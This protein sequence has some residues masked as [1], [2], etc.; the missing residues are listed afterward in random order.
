MIVC[1]NCRTKLHVPVEPQTGRRV[2]CPKCRAAFEAAAATAHSDSGA[3]DSGGLPVVQFEGFTLV[4]AEDDRSGGGAWFALCCLT[5]AILAAVASLWHFDVT[6]RE[7]VNGFLNRNA[8]PAEAVA[9]S[10]TEGTRGKGDAAGSRSVGP[11]S[12]VGDRYAL[13]V[14]V[15]DYSKASGLKPLKFTGDDARELS[16]VLE[17]N[18][19]RDENVVLMTAAEAGPQGRFSPR[20]RN[21]LHELKTLVRDRAAGDSLLVAF[22]GHGV[23]LEGKSY[24]CPVDARLSDKDTLI[25]MDDVYETLRT[26]KA[27]LKLMLLDAC[28]DDPFSSNSRRAEVRLNSSTRPALPPPPGGVVAL[29]SCSSGEVSFEDDSLKHGVFTYYV[30]EALRGKADTNDDGQIDVYELVQY[31][32]RRVPD[33]VRSEFD[34]LRQRPNLMGDII[35]SPV[36][37]GRKVVPQK[38]A[39]PANAPPA[40]PEPVK[41]AKT[42]TA[43]P[44]KNDEP[45]GN[46][47]APA[48]APPQQSNPRKNANPRPSNDRPP[49]GK[50]AANSSIPKRPGDAANVVDPGL[51]APPPFNQSQAG[52]P[53]TLELPP[54]SNVP[55]EPCALNMA[56]LKPPALPAGWKADPG[57]VSADMQGFRVLKSNVDHPVTALSPPIPIRGDFYIDLET[58]HGTYFELTLVGDNA[59]DLTLGF[60]ERYGSWIL[61]PPGVRQHSLQRM[62]QPEQMVMSHLRIERRGRDFVV[63]ANGQDVGTGNTGPFAYRYD[64]F[65][66]FKGLVLRI[67]ESEW[68][69]GGLK[70]GPLV[71]RKGPAGETTPYA[72]ESAEGKLPEGWKYVGRPTDGNFRIIAPAE[73]IDVKG[74]FV[75]EFGCV[76]QAK[77]VVAVTLLGRDGDKPLKVAFRRLQDMLETSFPMVKDVR[78][79]IGPYGQR[80]R[81][82]GHHF[83]IRIERTDGN[84]L[85]S[86]NG[87]PIEQAVQGDDRREFNGLQIDVYA[88]TFLVGPLRI[89]PGRPEDAKSPPPPAP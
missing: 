67:H 73:K 37:A 78:Y 58:G 3:G 83:P 35:G 82:D 49:A 29:F 8:A 77:A 10:E 36:L 68:G 89:T 45:P 21:I 34:G 48:D 85:L 18:G 26:C 15:K 1:P 39:P 40:K 56:D 44:A 72:P 74:D 11:R 13:L 19:Y 31:T 24:F 23:Q 17:S 46:A 22:F 80:G 88:G 57:F 27:D 4:P 65:G 60:R 51:P 25:S 81:S 41:L 55:G 32:N 38:P 20:S 7:V 61:Y 6:P 5:F 42:T 52:P 71:E 50:I 54:I 59:P 47:V 87:Q 84:L 76:T 9:Q 2:R 63:S 70:I 86:V 30:L 69:F 43:K 14:G 28:R 12:G 16:S 53:E 64:H 75:L 79:A 33:Y 66:D 62:G